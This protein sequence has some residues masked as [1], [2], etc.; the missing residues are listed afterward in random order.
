VDYLFFGLRFGDV[1]P[2]DFNTRFEEGF[3]HLGY[4]HTEQVGDLLRHCVIW[5]RSLIRITLLLELHVAKEQ[6]GRHD[7]EDRRQVFRI[8]AHYRHRFTRLLKLGHVVHAI[9]G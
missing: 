9:D 5:Q 4:V 2:S 7:A 3:C 1:I 6:C 8:H